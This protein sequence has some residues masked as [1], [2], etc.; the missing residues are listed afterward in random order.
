MRFYWLSRLGCVDGCDP[1]IQIL[2]FGRPQHGTYCS[3]LPGVHDANVCRTPPIFTAA[4]SAASSNLSGGLT[5]GGG[6]CAYDIKGSFRL[7]G[8]R[9]RCTG[10]ESSCHL[11]DT[12]LS[13]P[14]KC[15]KDPSRTETCQVVG[16]ASGAGLDGCRQISHRCHRLKCTGPSQVCVKTPLRIIGE[17][18]VY[19]PHEFY[20]ALE[21]ILAD[22]SRPRVG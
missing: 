19:T 22:P 13:P 3:P 2:A 11:Q 7:S 18:A 4:E 21:P 12:P 10:P 8:E 15:G 5:T 17:R 9:G 14:F 16:W 1:R 6:T 20:D